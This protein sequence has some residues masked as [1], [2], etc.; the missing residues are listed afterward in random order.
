M[1]MRCF[2]YGTP[3]DPLILRI[4]LGR[5][6]PAT[7]IVPAWMAGFALCAARGETFP[8]AIPARDGQIEGVVVSRLGHRD[9]ARLQWFEGSDYQLARGLAG[10]SGSPTAQS[11]LWFQPRFRL[12][13]SPAP[14]RID[15]WR[16]RRRRGFAIFASRRM[17]R[18]GGNVVI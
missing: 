17:Q 18:V 16:K 14:W 11:V 8:V 1:L 7:S 2:F 5:R 13:A 9:L 15:R 10:I 6:V 12:K 3:R 4:V